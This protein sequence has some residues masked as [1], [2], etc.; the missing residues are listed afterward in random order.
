MEKISD[1]LLKIYKKEWKNNNILECGANRNGS[2]TSYF[3]PNNECWYLEP[4]K[5]EYEKLSIK[6]KN[7]LNLALSDVNGKIKFINCENSGYSSCNYSKEQ[8]LELVELKQNKF[9]ETKVQSI[10]YKKLL[11]RLNLIFDVF[12]L[13]VEGHEITILNTLKDLS[14]EKLPQIIVIECGYDWGDRLK[15]LKKIGYNIDCYYYNNC[16]LSR[17]KVEVN[18]DIKDKI[19]NEWKIFNWRGKLIYKNELVK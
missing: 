12:V 7:T 9:N 18:N 13:D 3:E 16:Y 1:I 11:E 17:G 4:N 19:N 14:E 8:M 2:E 5:K 15:V 10:T 6:R